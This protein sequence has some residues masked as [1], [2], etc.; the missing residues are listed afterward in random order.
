MKR[1]IGILLTVSGA[2]LASYGYTQVQKGV[3]NYFFNS[4]MSASAA[5]VQ[6]AGGSDLF[7]IGMIIFA[8]GGFIL[9]SVFLDLLS[10]D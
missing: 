3:V 8:I 10:R 4:D 6:V 1:K 2:I 9:L 5:N 7:T